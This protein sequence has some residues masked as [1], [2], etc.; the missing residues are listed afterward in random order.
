M[1]QNNTPSRWRS[2]RRRLLL[3]IAAALFVFVP[4]GNALACGDVPQPHDCA[5]HFDCGSKPTPNRTEVP[6][7]PPTQAP[8][9]VDTPASPATA[10]CE[11][12]DDTCDVVTGNPGFTG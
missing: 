6:T 12:D 11:G 8:T 3:P 7:Q 9:P 5:N 4:A 10:E 1:S 2:V